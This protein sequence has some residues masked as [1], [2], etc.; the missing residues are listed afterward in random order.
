MW[1]LI[2]ALH[3]LSNVAT[4]NTSPFSTFH[5][6]LVSLVYWAW[7]AEPHYLAARAQALALTT[8]TIGTHS[9]GRRGTAEI[10]ALVLLKSVGVW[11]SH[12]SWTT[13]Q[14]LSICCG[15]L[16]DPP[17]SPMYLQILYLILSGNRHVCE[18]TKNCKELGFGKNEQSEFKGGNANQTPGW[19]R[20][21]VT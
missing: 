20:G 9:Y 4:L 10:S 1:V 21:G 5:Y 14:S 8:L 12:L 16:T 6:F 2:G 7:V 18:A 13:P 17:Q 15:L 19:L 3:S 11:M